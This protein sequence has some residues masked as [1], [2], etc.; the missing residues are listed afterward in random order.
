MH[1]FHFIYPGGYYTASQAGLNLEA[2]IRGKTCC[3][4]EQAIHTFLL[5]NY[6]KNIKSSTDSVPLHENYCGGGGSES[7]LFVLFAKVRQFYDAFVL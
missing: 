6:Y 2:D 4:F 3:S 5:E 1:Q 7:S